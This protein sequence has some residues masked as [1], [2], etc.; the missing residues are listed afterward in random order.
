MGE[1]KKN[2]QLQ[3]FTVRNFYRGGNGRRL[4]LK[5]SSKNSH[6][7]LTSR[8]MSSSSSN[9]YSVYGTQGNIGSPL[10]MGSLQNLNRS[11]SSL[12]QLSQ[13]ALRPS[14]SSLAP[15]SGNPSLMGFNS[16]VGGGR[17]T[18]T[19][20]G[21]AASASGFS[22]GP[23]GFPG[24]GLGFG[25][26]QPPQLSRPLGI[27]QSNSMPSSAAVSGRNPLFNTRD[28]RGKIGES[29]SAFDPSEFP[30]LG[31][32]ENSSAPNPALA[33]S[34]YV[35]MVGQ[36]AMEASEFTMSNEDF[37]A[38]PGPGPNS[39]G[40]SAP[41]APAPS[42]LGGMSAASTVAL[43][44]QLG[45]Q[46]GV[47]GNNTLSSEMMLQ[48][49]QGTAGPGE[50]PVRQQLQQPRRGI[51]TSSSGLVTNI[52][53]SMVTD[54]FGMIGLLTFIRAAE[55]DPNLVSLALGADLTTL[56][57]NLNSG[58][59]LYP[60][61]GGPWAETPC[62][63]QDIDYHVP[64]EYLTNT[65]IREKLAPVKLNRYKD[66][67]LFYMFYTNVGDVL[68]MAAA[69]ELYNRDWR[70][71]KEERVWITRAPGMAPSEKTTT[72]ERGTYYFFDV[73]LW[74]KVPKEFHLDYDKLE[75]R[76][77]LPSNLAGAGGGAGGS[78]S[79][80]GGHHP[81]SGSPQPLVP[82]Q[83]SAPGAG[84]NIGNNAL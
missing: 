16:A 21:S 51:Q 41:A 63:P 55:T 74:K 11:G 42:G 4:S 43:P 64:H 44:N 53:T 29:L 1:R 3:S 35:G 17:I 45:Q 8:L 39:A 5:F 19:S 34:N 24:G 15:G 70:Y 58:V 68:Q 57:L 66:D 67:I 49:T 71:H 78:Q 52:P 61:F 59:N 46:Q 30:S 60:T 62:R 48:S 54:Q 77:S 7:N 18:P 76:P 73:N 22:S 36:P 2:T 28:G 84:D 83:V 32:R 9:P 69:A 81:V 6:Q 26:S 20:S 33:R 72:Y 80:V 31:S 37:P 75:D 13:A 40:R 50:V 82:T 10:G 47:I 65:A 79:T 12:A 56:G 23:S 27:L 25:S 38:L 14:Q